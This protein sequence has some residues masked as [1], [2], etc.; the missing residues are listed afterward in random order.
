MEIVI[1]AEFLLEL[2]TYDISVH[3]DVHSLD[4]N[5]FILQGL[6]DFVILRSPEPYLDISTID[7]YSEDVIVI[8]GT[9]DR[10]MRWSGDGITYSEWSTVDE[11]I[12]NIPNSLYHK[13]WI[14]WK[15][16]MIT[17]GEVI[18][19]WARLDVSI[20][21]SNPD[22]CFIPIPIAFPISKGNGYYPVSLG[23]DAW[24]NPQ[25]D[26]SPLKNLYKDLDFMVNNVYGHEVTYFQAV[27]QQRSRDIVFLE[28]TIYDVAEPRCIKIVVPDGQF[29][30]SKFNFTPWGIEFD[31]PFEVHLDK[32]YFEY[33][34]GTNSMPQKRDIIFFPLVNRLYEV[35]SST[36]FRDFLQE[37]IY[38]KL[39]LKKYQ[40]RSNVGKSEVIRG[41]LEE[42]TQGLDEVF[43][44]ELQNDIHKITNPQQF[45]DKS[46]Y[47]DPIRRF[48]DR[49]LVIQQEDIL[50]FS[51]RIAHWNYNMMGLFVDS[52]NTYTPAI[53]YNR[54]PDISI[55][56]DMSFTCWFREKTQ[57][58]QFKNVLSVTPYGSG[59]MYNIR[60]KVQAPRL[61]VGSWMKL[62]SPEL[63]NFSLHGEIFDIIPDKNEIRV[64]FEEGLLNTVT[65]MHP[66]WE[67]TNSLTGRESFRRVFLQSYDSN[68]FNGIMVDSFDSN[69]FR[70]FLN[71]QIHYLFMDSP[72]TKDKWYGMVLNISNTNCQLGLHLW[73]LAPS[74]E[75]TT[76]LRK[77]F[78]SIT[79]GIQPQV[80]KQ[81]IP[82]SIYSSALD[83]TNVRI[84]SCIIEE[85]KQSVFLNQNIVKDADRA[86]VIDNAEPLSRLPRIASG[87]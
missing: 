82:Y 85:E 25:H 61:K 83:I 10:E 3:A 59:G 72:L 34:F 76:I 49:G 26:F 13:F 68:K 6:G 37:P 64:R 69:Y 8:A 78:T 71:N 23:I 47:S 48:I 24:W 54:K 11:G 38:Y 67:I 39:N 57:K 52:G 16:S 84:M 43:G 28:W 4:S 51:T 20:S 9:Y 86:I 77:V 42:Y 56:N 40:D 55:D 41:T 1:L 62:S 2:P 73:D 7:G 19:Q 14:E 31:Y 35:D 87:R 15:Y 17:P 33:M 27:P 36:L 29:P 75:R 44:K 74:E 79:N 50:N 66:N 46:T 21:E 58:V 30:D 45:D 65:A 70:I 22:N 12:D 18:I 5:Q 60:F 81:E 32:R 80:Y 53:E 63:V